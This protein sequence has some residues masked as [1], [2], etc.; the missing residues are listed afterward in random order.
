MSI[1]SPSSYIPPSM[2]ERKTQSRLVDMFKIAFVEYFEYINVKIDAIDIRAIE[3][4]N[5]RSYASLGGGYEP[6]LKA[7]ISGKCDEEQFKHLKKII[8]NY[9]VERYPKLNRDSLYGASFTNEVSLINK[10]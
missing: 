6:T 7:S 10:W 1:Y 8:I 9:N 2:A 3:Y 4:G 5:T